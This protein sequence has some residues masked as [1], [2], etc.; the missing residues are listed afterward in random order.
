MKA[1]LNFIRNLRS[2]LGASCIRV[3]SLG[4]AFLLMFQ[5]L[6]YSSELIWID[7]LDVIAAKETLMIKISRRGSNM[8]MKVTLGHGL[9]ARTIGIVYDEP[10]EGDNVEKLE[11][12]PTRLNPLQP[13][14]KGG[15][16]TEGLK[17]RFPSSRCGC[18][19]PCDLS[20]RR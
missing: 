6:A 14:P 5:G 3:P 18:L 19:L 4:V 7:F 15:E 17:K 1:F 13:G 8:A 9:S 12:P 16:G 11:P 2:E 20:R 10:V